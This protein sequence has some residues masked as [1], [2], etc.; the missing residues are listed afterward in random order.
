[1]KF[2][3]IIGIIVVLNVLFNPRWKEAYRR[4]QMSE[5]RDAKNR[6][7]WL[8]IAFCLSLGNMVFWFSR[9]PTL[10]ENPK[11]KTE[12]ITVAMNSSFNNGE[13]VDTRRKYSLYLF[14]AVLIYSS[15]HAHLYE[16]KLRKQGLLEEGS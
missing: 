15:I 6:P 14:I 8:T 12:I 3:Q 9:P 16:R 4:R 13:W 1:M 2:C 5:M 10:N 7:L 11:Q